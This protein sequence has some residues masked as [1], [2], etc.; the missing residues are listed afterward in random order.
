M[1]DWGI[2]GALALSGVVLFGWNLVLGTRVTALPSAGRAFRILSGLCAFLL[3]PALVIGLLA[4]TAPGARILEPLAWLWPVVVVAIATQAL[5]ALGG[6]RTSTAVA[7]PIALYD[8]VVAWVAATR[9]IEGQGALLPAWSLA[10]GMAVSTIGA[11]VLGD[12]A[13][14]WSAAVLVPLLVPAAPARSSLSG[15]WRAVVVTGCLVAV[16]LVGAETSSA[17]GAI[18]A[19]RVLGT[20]TMPERARPEFAVGLRL[21][22]TLDGAPYS[23]VARHDVALADS[24]GITAVHLELGPE[25][26]ATT[27]LDSIARSIE[28]RRDSLVL[29]VTLD[30][31]RGDRRALRTD[32]AWLR[33]RLAL[34]EQIVQHL[35]PDVLLPADGV[36]SPSDAGAVRWWQSYYERAARSARRIDRDVSIAL[37]TD[38]GTPADSALCDWV[39]QGGSPVDAVALLVR[40]HGGTPSRFTGALAAVTRWASLARAAPSVWL[41]AVPASPAVAGEVAQQRLVRHA[42]Q[43]GASRTWVRGVIAGDASDVLSITGLRT[44]TGRSRGALAEV[45][46]ALR[47]LRDTPVVAPIPADSAATDTLHSTPDSMNP[48]RP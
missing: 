48:I 29:V 24:L 12:G 7:L 40:P 9:W 33:A 20:G 46:I 16:V 38:A 17:Y 28:A 15:A 37:A 11:T 10:P 45:G 22:G 47:A 39:M 3:I 30:M 19:A 23:A 5:W 18:S 13:F 1:T 43:W 42:L 21:F 2:P 34:I 26:A 8:L 41:M 4:P 44:A 35:N 27:A 6:G 32:D 31:A 25:G 14:L 36:A